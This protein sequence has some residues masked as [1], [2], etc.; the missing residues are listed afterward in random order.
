MY[1]YDPTAWEENR[2]QLQQSLSGEDAMLQEL[3]AE[4]YNL[5]LQASAAPLPP[6]YEGYTMTGQYVD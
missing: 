6:E 5:D 4:K 3:D 2:R 1:G